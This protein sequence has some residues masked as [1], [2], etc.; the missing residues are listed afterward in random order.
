M[1]EFDRK[2]LAAAIA[3]RIKGLRGKMNQTEFAAKCGTSQADISR[4]ESGGCVP[5]VESLML[6]A[7]GCRVSVADIIGPGIRGMV[8]ADNEAAA[9]VKPAEVVND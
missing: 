3:K 4:W 6:I 5:A 1:S 8:K 9:K 2:N 7:K